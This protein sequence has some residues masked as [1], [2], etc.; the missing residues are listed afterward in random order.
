MSHHI[1]TKTATRA[2]RRFCVICGWRNR[3]HQIIDLLGFTNMCPGEELLATSIAKWQRSHPPLKPDG[4]LGPK[5]WR[6]M[7]PETRYSPDFRAPR[8]GWLSTPIHQGKTHESCISYYHGTSK[9]AGERLIDTDITPFLIAQLAQ[10]APGNY[11]DFTDFGKGFYTFDKTGKRNAFGRAKRRNPEWAV[12]EFLVTKSEDRKIR[13]SL[14]LYSNKKSRPGNSPIIRNAASFSCSGGRP[15]SWLEFVEHN[16]HVE[17]RPGFLCR[18]RIQRPA[19]KDYTDKYSLM[20]GPL[21]VP[22]DSGIDEGPP[23]SPDSLH[24]FNFGKV[25]LGVLNS[26]DC[27]S[28]RILHTKKQEMVPQ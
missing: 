14:L 2:N 15:A 22:R 11:K 28:R 17:S 19:D 23:K 26:E 27:K 20:V 10:M 16:R 3:F 21:W 24:Q 6:I 1:D 4:I 13:S 12:V 8:P 25:G 9:S 5:T 7:E 18:F